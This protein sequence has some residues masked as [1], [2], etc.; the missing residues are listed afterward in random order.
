MSI[1]GATEKEK[2]IDGYLILIY[3]NYSTVDYA[4]KYPKKSD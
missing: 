1:I 3:M 2:K 4:Y